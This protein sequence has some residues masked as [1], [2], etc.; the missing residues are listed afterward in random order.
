MR[1]RANTFSSPSA[2]RGAIGIVAALTLTS[3][4]LFMMLALDSGRLYWEGQE[5]QRLA[6]LAAIDAATANSDIF[7]GVLLASAN[8][9]PIQSAAEDS[10][11]LNGAAGLNVP[12]SGVKAEQGALTLN[13]SI[14]SFST[15]GSGAFNEAV[16]VTVSKNVCG[17]V[18]ASLSVLIPDSDYAAPAGDCLTPGFLMTRE[19]VAR[20]SAYVA[21]SAG[22]TL[23]SLDT[24]ESALLNPILEQLLGS[25]INLAALGTSGILAEDISLLQLSEGISG[26][27]INSSVGT[28][29]GLLET[30]LSA[31]EL[32]DSVLYVLDRD[33]NI[34]L[35]RLRGLRDAMVNTTLTARK[36]LL[37]NIL[38][39]HTPLDGDDES[40]VLAAGVTLG[41]LLNAAIMLANQCAPGPNAQCTTG[42]IVVP[43]ADLNLLGM[44]NISNLSLSIIKPPVIAVGPPGCADGS[45]PLLTEPGCISWRTEATPA[46]IALS[47][48]LNVSLGG[49]LSLDLS[50]NLSGVNGRAGVSS[51]TKAAIG[52]N[53]DYS[54][55]IG[56]YT[57]LAST[58]ELS[59]TLN[60]L[61][62]T[63]PGLVQSILNGLGNIL[64][65]L[66]VETLLEV[67]L[68]S[69]TL[70]PTSL[71]LS[72]GSGGEENFHWSRATEGTTADKLQPDAVIGGEVNL[73]GAL[74]SL[75]NV[76]SVTL[77]SKVQKCLVKL[78]SLC[79][80]LSGPST[81]NITINLSGLLPATTT[82]TTLVG[83]LLDEQLTPLLH[84]LGIGINPMDVE[85]LD[86]HA[87]APQ[88]VI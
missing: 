36:I 7:N 22:T 69:V 85:I 27:G 26:L 80:S 83:N 75:L 15:A 16:K 64:G 68:P 12:L 43:S 41:D 38:Q 21:F 10:A 39:I 77:S 2:Q 63:N 66:G 72:G 87:G 59:A 47:A 55:S 82:L 46:Q 86:I 71:V 50:L 54:V 73:G 48:K 40:S 4:I 1:P 23:L 13:D 5:L 61:N 35:S 19:A 65:L 67:N 29:D 9:D 42:A 56:G 84:A 62:S 8:A 32:L 37:G 45:V 76:P 88:L 25:S 34:D 53:H 60:L 18:I 11:T 81:Q 70:G 6:D 51:V 14:R 74:T 20:R 28:L 52:A 33:S 24:S 58:N 78:V 30:N 17:S 31:G 79:I 3:A 57:S 44:V 49:L